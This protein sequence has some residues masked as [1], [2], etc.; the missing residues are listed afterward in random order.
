MSGIRRGIPLT[1]ALIG[2]TAF[3]DDLSVGP[4]GDYGTISAALEEAEDGDRLLIEAG[5]YS[6]FLDFDEMDLILEAQGAVTL[7]AP[8]LGV[9]RDAMV[10]VVESE[11]SFIG[12]TFQVANSAG[13]ATAEDS[14]LTVTDCAFT[15]AA[16]SV[17]GGVRFIALGGGSLTVSGTSF[18]GGGSSDLESGAHIAANGAEINVTASTFTEGAAGAGGS[19]AVEDSSLTVGDS[20]FT[21]N[22]AGSNGGPGSAGGAILTVG[23]TLAITG[24]EFIGGTTRGETSGTHIATIEG[25]VATIHDCTFDG[26]DNP[27]LGGSLLVSEGADMTITNSA[28][29][30]NTVDWYGGAILIVDATLEVSDSTFVGNRTTIGSTDERAG[31]IIALDGS[32]LFVY[33]T[34][35][36]DNTSNG[37]GG[38]IYI[39]ENSSSTISESTFTGNASARGGAIRLNGNDGATSLD[40]IGSTFTGNESAEYGGGLGAVAA[41][42]L[43][44]TDNT[45][46]DNVSFRGGGMSVFYTADVQIGGNVFCGNSADGHGGGARV[47]GNSGPNRWFNNVFVDNTAGSGAG[48]GGIYFEDNNWA[49]VVNNDFM[50]NSGEIGGGGVYVDGSG[51]SIVN[52]LF[53]WTHDG[54]AV[55]ANEPGSVS[56]EYN[57]FHDNSDGDL[58]GGLTLGT[59]N[60]AQFPALQ[61]YTRDGDCTD[62]NYHLRPNSPLRD[63]GDPGI[64]DPD[65]TVSDIGAFGGPDVDGDLFVDGDTDGTVAA[66]DCD[67]DDDTRHENAVELCD[68]IDNNCDGVTDGADATN[69]QTWYADLDGDDHGDIGNTEEACDAPDGYVA[70]SD[71]CDDTNEDIYPSAPEICDS[72]D[73]D[74]D[75][76]IDEAGAT[77]VETWYADV[78]E[79]GYGDIDDGIESCA[80]IDGR[81]PNSDDCADDNGDIHPGADEHCDDVDEDCDE[82]IDEDPVNPIIFYADADNDGYGD[83]LTT[84]GACELPDGYSLSGGDCNDADARFHPSAEENCDPPYE[85]FN[86]DGFTGLDD[87]DLD[88]SPACEDCDDGDEFIYPDAPEIWYDGDDQNCDGASDFDADGDGYDVDRFGGDDCNDTNPEI[89]PGAEESLYDLVDSNCDGEIGVDPLGSESL[90]VGCSGC[91]AGGTVAPLSTSLASVFFACLL[92]LFRRENG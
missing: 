26:A 14:D 13:I 57:D 66:Y 88:G 84:I 42:E 24:S 56:V 29:S 27:W 45:F 44:A 85:D 35:F 60:I 52:N 49:D 40:L 2:A 4:S 89:N 73:N 48:G 3:A 82:E 87:N 10:T 37:E 91:T 17:S 83:R 43:M 75:G 28:F 61:Y 63:A 9:G 22:E 55:G 72:K 20:V 23:G 12:M 46:T 79:D 36:D 8:G 74:C 39:G 5:S 80:A 11:V 64:T 6:E 86:C 30:N 38:A 1:L 47:T 50:D 81:V 53:A 90:V 34:T 18:N 33:R 59:G 15:S 7:S 76:D 51:A 41:D 25:T 92:V 54:E 32:S 62:D 77:G 68:G 70:S 67:D 19:I 78:D 69:A 21:D 65:T 58:T 71:D 16:T 31:A